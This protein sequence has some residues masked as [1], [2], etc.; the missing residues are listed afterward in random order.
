MTYVH[1]GASYCLRYPARFVPDESDPDRPRIVGPALDTSLQPVRAALQVE[2]THLATGVTADEAV[3]AFVAGFAGA[4]IQRRDLQVG[5]EPAVLLE[6][7]PGL[8]GSRDVIMVRGEGLYRLLFTPSVEGFPQAGAD[9][10]D[11]FE[12]VIA[13]FTIL[14]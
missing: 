3:D 2:V 4:S 11:L 5:D 8:G 9:V 1:Q 13:S 10:E 7:V 6:G 12:T 14:N